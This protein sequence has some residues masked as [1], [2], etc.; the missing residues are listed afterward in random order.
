MLCL[1][2]LQ[3]SRRSNANPFRLALLETGTDA[4]A[5]LYQ[6]GANAELVL[7]L[8]SSCC[9]CSARA[10]PMLSSCCAC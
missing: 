9:V 8:L 2:G 6:F 10:V 7:R 4:R 3:L 5:V 1:L